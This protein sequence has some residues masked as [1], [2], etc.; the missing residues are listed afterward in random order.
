MKMMQQPKVKLRKEYTRGDWA[1]VWKDRALTLAFKILPPIRALW[2]LIS[3]L[4]NN[5]CDRER[6]DINSTNCSE[7]PGAPT[8]CTSCL[9]RQWIPESTKAIKELKEIWWGAHGR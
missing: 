8:L 3:I 1:K 6:F 5:T 7:L 2:M 9:V 4:V